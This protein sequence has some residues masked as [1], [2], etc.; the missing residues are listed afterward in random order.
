MGAGK[1]SVG[2]QLAKLTG[3]SWY[4]SD[5]EIKRRTGVPLAW[6][7]ETE[8]ESG[9]R[10]REYLIISELS[11]LDNI[12]LSTGGGSIVSPDNRVV[13]KEHGFVAYL[14][15]SLNEQLHRT[16]IHKE[17]RPLI[18]LP[19]PK[20]KLIE[21]NTERAPLYESIADM[22]CDTDKLTPKKVAQ[23]ILDAY[24]KT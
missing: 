10:L 8:Q 11:Q 20:P 21:L 23:N 13:L 18:D 24:E 14:K 4:D 3:K 12:I 1:S 19:D 15:V 22:I 9:F 5:A 7:F 6:I 2:I 17:T 16:K